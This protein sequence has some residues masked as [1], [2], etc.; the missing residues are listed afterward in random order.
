MSQLTEDQLTVLKALMVSDPPVDDRTEAGLSHRTGLS[1][2]DVGR[3]LRE[4]DN[5]FDPPLVKSDVDE[6]LHTRF[7]WATEAAGDLLDQLDE[8]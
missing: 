8:A 1:I 3:L 4:L 2:K 6:T 7:W 5:N